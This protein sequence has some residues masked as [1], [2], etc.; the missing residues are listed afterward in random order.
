MSYLVR[1]LLLIAAAIG[2]FQ[3]QVRHE[4]RKHAVPALHYFALGL[5]IF[6]ITAI[7][8]IIIG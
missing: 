1:R 2:I 4:I 7:I 8:L 6:F 5:L 3:P